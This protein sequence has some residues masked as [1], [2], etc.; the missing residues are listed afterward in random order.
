MYTDAVDL[1]RPKKQTIGSHTTLGI[2]IGLERQRGR[3]IWAATK[4]ISTRTC[5]AAAAAIGLFGSMALMA[6]G[7]GF[8]FISNQPS[9]RPSVR[10]S[11]RSFL[12]LFL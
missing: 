8:H 12:P 3:R 11:V 2:G 6:I 1:H 4:R 9:R 7:L 5:R 10:P